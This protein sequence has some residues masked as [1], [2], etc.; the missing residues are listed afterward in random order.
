VTSIAADAVPANPPA[1]SARAIKRL[2]WERER[3]TLKRE[4]DRLQELGTDPYSDEIN[5][6]SRR[7]L[8]VGV[9]LNRYV[10]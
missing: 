4:L 6:L 5:T 2:R 9:E 10:T 1:E 7:L 3:A 8:A